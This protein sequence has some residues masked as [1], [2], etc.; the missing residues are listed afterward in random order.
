MPGTVVERAS[1]QGAAPA[2][3][4]NW[5]GEWVSDSGEVVPLSADQSKRLEMMFLAYNDRL[6]GYARKRLVLFGRD[7]STAQWQ[8]EDVVQAMWGQVARNGRRD[9]LGDEPLAEDALLRLLYTRTKYALTKVQQPVRETAVDWSDAVVCNWLC[10][11]VPEGCAAEALPAYLAKMVAALPEQ[12]REALLLTLDGLPGRVAAQ[13]LQCSRTQVERLASTAVLL[14]QI[15][16]PE[17][18]GPAVAVDTLP[19]WEREELGKLSA[20]KREALLRLDGQTR[21]ALLL[22]A[23]G[24]T[25]REVGERLGM[26][27][28]QV[29]VVNRCVPGARPAARAKTPAR[30]RTAAPKQ[31]NSRTTLVT[32]YWRERIAAMAPGERVSVYQGTKKRFGVG[33]SILDAATANLVAEGLI[34]RAGLRGYRVADQART[35]VSA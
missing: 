4:N 19:V 1:V 5:P 15:D 26:S 2:G 32:A 34:E 9:L 30:R 35:A 7:G 29:A 18:S 13:H 12:E 23:R 21:Q 17:L 3:R 11:L 20:A 6:V 24:M 22:R 28:E 14:L 27:K 10:P 8:A 16:N 33:N 25:A 31:A